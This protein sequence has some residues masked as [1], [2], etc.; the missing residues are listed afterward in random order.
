MQLEANLRQ[1]ELDQRDLVQALA[2]SRGDLE[3][4]RSAHDALSAE[5]SESRET[6]A[7]R[8]AQVEGLVAHVYDLRQQLQR[9]GTAALRVSEDEV[10]ASLAARVAAENRADVLAQEARHQAS[11]VAR[12]SRQ[13]DEANACLRAVMQERESV[14]PTEEAA[15]A[16]NV[17]LQDLEA[18]CAGLREELVSAGPSRHCCG[19]CAFSPLLAPS[20]CT[21]HTLLTLSSCTPHTLLAPSSLFGFRP[22]GHPDCPAGGAGGGFDATA[23]RVCPR[24]LGAGHAS[25]GAGCAPPA[26]LLPCG[27]QQRM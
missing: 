20:S 25:G 9:A 15:M 18:V 4:A 24:Q 13:L 8:E 11:A 27:E 16:S 1:A 3:K 26:L 12:L 23:G 21:P 5:V 22:E 6:L 19:G 2:A 7:G 17:S 14:A 10:A